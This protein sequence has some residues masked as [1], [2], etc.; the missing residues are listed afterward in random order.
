M[1]IPW[2]YAMVLTFTVSLYLWAEATQHKRLAYFCKP[3]STLV[4]IVLLLLNADMTYGFYQLVLLA[5]VGSLLGDIF[6]MLPSDKFIP[7]LAS[8]FIAHI[9]YALAFLQGVDSVSFHL[10]WLLPFGLAIALLGYLWPT[11]GNMKAP[12]LAYAV[13]I[14]G[15]LLS[16][17]ARYQSMMDVSSACLMVGAIFFVLSDA[18]IALDRFKGN[19]PYALPAIIVTYYVA[20]WLLV[21]GALMVSST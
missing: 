8:F 7:G 19:V 6:L 20:Q 2:P 17:I 3:A 18:L 16:T 4:L 13:I 10:S 21:S 15:M 5:L 11:L 1:V 9:A 14:I 12:V